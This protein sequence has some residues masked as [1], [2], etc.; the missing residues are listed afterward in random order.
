[1]RGFRRKFA[2]VAGVGTGIGRE[3]ACQLASEGC[4][5]PTCDTSVENMMETK[6]AC[7]ARPSGN[8]DQG[9]QRRAAQ[10]LRRA[11][12]AGLP[13]QGS[14]VGSGGGLDHLAGVRGEK[15]RIQDAHALDRRVREHPE[16]AYEPQMQA[17]GHFTEAAL[18]PAPTESPPEAQ[19]E[20]FLPLDKSRHCMI[21]EEQPS[22]LDV[23]SS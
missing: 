23:G 16:R 5:L 13:R 2:V 21:G 11:A 15:W 18:A 19:S 9:D 3:L 4:H 12:H 6:Q 17:E 22:A 20:P 1:M 14:H 10:G 8:P 7:Q